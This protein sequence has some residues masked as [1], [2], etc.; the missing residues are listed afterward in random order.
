MGVHLLLLH[1][2]L[3]SIGFMSITIL[4]AYNC[5]NVLNNVWLL[6]VAAKMQTNSI[7]TGCMHWKQPIL[8]W[9][10]CTGSHL[11]LPSF[12]CKKEG[13]WKLYSKAYHWFFFFAPFGYQR[14][15]WPIKWY[16]AVGTFSVNLGLFIS[17]SVPKKCYI[18]SVMY[19]T[20]KKKK[21]GY[22]NCSWEKGLAVKLKTILP[23][24]IKR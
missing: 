13:S 16:R 19:Y 3:L 15:T 20:N 8:K 17:I 2:Q 1:W 18:N 23:S 12:S 4:S 7:Y 5:F 6:C 14:H 24:Q 10:T 11:N 22:S 21:T 9:E